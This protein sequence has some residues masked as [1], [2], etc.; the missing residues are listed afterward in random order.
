MEGEF[1]RDCEEQRGCPPGLIM[2]VGEQWEKIR[3]QLI[4]GIPKDKQE[5]ENEGV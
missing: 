4:S 5:A 3:T 1:D 2:T